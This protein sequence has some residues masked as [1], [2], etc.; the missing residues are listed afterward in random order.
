MG[1]HIFN[2]SV[3]INNGTDSPWSLTATAAE[4]HADGAA[5]GPARALVFSTKL[6]DAKASVV[7]KGERL[8]QAGCCLVIE[9]TV[10]ADGP[11]NVE[12]MCFII[13]SCIAYIIMRFLF[14]YLE[15]LVMLLLL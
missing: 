9:G 8:G 1:V 6:V 13:L 14:Q 4:V 12:V 15:Y 7:G 11:L 10:K 3:T 5:G 2:A